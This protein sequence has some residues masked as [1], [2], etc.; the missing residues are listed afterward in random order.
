MT[1]MDLKANPFFLSDADIAW[2]ENTLAA[3]S[4]KEKIG[5][6]FVPVGFT[7]KKAELARLVKDVGIGGIMYRPSEGQKAQST[8]QFLQENA[9][10]P[11]LLAAN[12]EQGG[13]GAAS[14]G[15]LFA[16]PMGVAAAN[17][18]EMGYH[19]GKVSCSEGAALGLNWS[20]A[21]IVDVDLNYLN[22][23]ANLRT[24][25]SSP[26][27]IIEMAKGYIK[28]ADENGLAV[29]IKHFPGDGVDYRD[30]HILTSVNSLSCEEW[31]KTSGRVYSELIAAGAKTVMVGHIAQPAYQEAIEPG[32]GKDKVIPATLSKALMTGLLREKLGF[33]GV[34]STDASAM[35]GFTAAMS[36]SKAVPYAI[37]CGADVFLFNKDLDEDITYMTQG[38]ASGV[39]TRE[40]LDEA[41]T[42]ILAL[43]ASL[44]LHEKQAAGT[45]VPPQAALSVLGCA[46]HKR[47][48]R[49]CADKAVTLVKDTQN[50]L[51]ISP[52]THKRVY[53]NVLMDDNNPKAPM[54]MMWKERLEKEGF[55]VFLQE[56]A[57]TAH[58]MNVLTGEGVSALQK[59]KAMPQMLR[60][61]KSFGGRVADYANQYDLCIFVGNFP[62][63]SNATTIRISW[64]GLGGIGND[65]PWCPH[66]IPT[67][68][69][70]MANPY[71]MQDVP[72]IPTFINAYTHSEITVDAV[73]E[74]I[75]GRSEFKGVSPVDASCGSPYNML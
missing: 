53:L 65:T 45:L 35:L 28:A 3:M 12:L 61:M 71:H 58:L 51:P 4:E 26:D 46:E 22:P 13:S 33:N 43:K 48:A 29:S 64:R 39:L 72:M 41:V 44:K 69:I 14:D 56:R 18:A 34:I 31:D 75:M 27:K 47:L 9:K 38:L 24:F 2:V 57:D 63:A 15:T 74:K 62:T 25:G 70:S 11:L 52:K 17:D 7:T 68:F 37:A 19:L 54:R 36:R 23:I 30:Q 59:L 66:E 73:V 49:D 6:L 40:R 8:H 10:I 42:R 67:M 16:M 32:S 60:V 21:P 5:Q 20:F 50:L 55:E 1:K